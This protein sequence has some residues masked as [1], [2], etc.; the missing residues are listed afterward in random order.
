MRYNE[1][2]KT[3]QATLRAKHVIILA[4]VTTGLL[5]VPFIAMQFTSEVAWS[6]FDFLVMGALI[7]GTGLLIN[8]VP[9]KAGNYRV[10]ARVAAIVG[11][12]FLFLWVW[13]ELAVGGF[14]HLGS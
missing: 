9:R 1:D 8:M 2:M 13:A 7:F 5:L 14:T 10:A 4:I 11:I 3:A 6:P 12:I